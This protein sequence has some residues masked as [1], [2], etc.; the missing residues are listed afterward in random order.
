MD[1]AV[2]TSA[3]PRIGTVDSQSGA[4][5][6]SVARVAWTSARRA[7]VPT[8]PT[9]ASATAMVSPRPSSVLVGAAVDVVEQL[10]GQGARG[11]EPWTGWP[12]PCWCRWR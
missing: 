3:M 12:D 7:N 6:R 10:V 9:G 11:W 5:N 2:A 8:R 4:P 1:V